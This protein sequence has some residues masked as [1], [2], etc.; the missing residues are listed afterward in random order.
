MMNINRLYF[1]VL[2]SIN[3]GSYIHRLTDKYIKELDDCTIFIHRR[4]FSLPR[5]RTT[6]RVQTSITKTE[7]H[8]RHLP[9]YAPLQSRPSLAYRSRHVGF[10]GEWVPDVFPI[11]GPTLTPPSPDAAR[12]HVVLLVTD[13]APTPPAPYRRRHS[14]SLSWR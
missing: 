12:P 9:P 6:S 10:I 11:A 2:K 7:P 8:L 3:E 5:A 1:L 13:P 14:P 4:P